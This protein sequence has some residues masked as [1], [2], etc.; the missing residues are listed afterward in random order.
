MGCIQSLQ[1]R[2]P[3]GSLWYKANYA[4]LYT[5]RNTSVPTISRT[6]SYK[7]RLVQ[8]SWSCLR[9]SVP[10]QR[11]QQTNSAISRRNSF[12]VNPALC[13]LK[14]CVESGSALMNGVSVPG[15]GGERGEA[16]GGHI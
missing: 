11:R 7:L 14:V 3:F 2:L 5:Q 1:L 10:K 16:H 15:A 8:N 13:V 6:V 12:R 4:P 9:R